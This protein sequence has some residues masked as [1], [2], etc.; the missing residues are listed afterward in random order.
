MISLQ[1][2]KSSTNESSYVR[3]SITGE[4]HLEFPRMRSLCFLWSKQAGVSWTGL[5]QSGPN[6]IFLQAI[7]NS[8]VSGPVRHRLSSRWTDSHVT[9][10][11]ACSNSLPAT[12]SRSNQLHITPRTLPCKKGE[13]KIHANI[14]HLTQLD[15]PP[16]CTYIPLIL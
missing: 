8:G 16:T 5:R 10:V 9:L 11:I 7:N 6:R 12:P 1:H 2:W 3:S 15:P 13:R 4:A 14:T